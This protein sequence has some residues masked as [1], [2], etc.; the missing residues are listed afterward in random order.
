[1]A[2][3]NE[4]PGTYDAVQWDGETS[5][6]E[7]ITAMHNATGGGDIYDYTING[8]VLTVSEVMGSET[9]ELGEWA[10][11]GPYWDVSEGSRMAK[12]NNTQFTARFN[13]QA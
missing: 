13:V 7:T 8:N 2:L 12:F 4:K 3:Y 11:H 6:A 10:V 9:Y 1:M 5:T